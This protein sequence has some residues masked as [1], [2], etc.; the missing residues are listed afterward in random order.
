MR[1]KNIILLS[2]IAFIG[3]V[4]FFLV[5]KHTYES[6]VEALKVK[7]KE[8]FIMAL[9]QELKNRNLNGKLSFYLDLGAVVSEVP[10]TVYWEDS[11]GRYF[12][13]IDSKKKQMNIVNDVNMRSLHSI[14]FRK[15]PLI[16][17]SLILKWQEQL[18]VSDIVLK[19]ALRVSL[20]NQDGSVKLSDSAQCG[21]WCNS[22][23]LVFTVYIGYAYEIEA[24]GYLEYTIWSILYKEMLLFLL[25][26]V[27]F[28]YGLYR[29]WNVLSHKIHTLRTPAVRDIIKE[30]P[31]EIIKEVQVEKLVLKE[32]QRVEDSPLHSYLLGENIIF[33][34][35]Q[36]IIE[37]NGI[38]RNIQAQS[39]LLLDLFLKQK[40][41]GYTLNED[42]IIDKLWPDN[43]GNHK[44]MH[45]AIARLRSF[46]KK[47]DP[48]LSIINK[49][50]TYQLIIS[51]KRIIV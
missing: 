28:G 8:A 13:K 11:T 38:M 6:K 21:E 23:N 17:D 51:G 5:C 36:N 40:D 29:F 12:Y 24:M 33:Y 42:L 15:T 32:V 50:G 30:V 31:V 18:L 4:L 48:S 39:G 26:Y 1:A 20:I 14:V 46:L 25:L 43:S 49:N 22:S 16:S 9:N 3:G 45:K 47:I 7:S 35:D 41:N 10:N 2:V 27:I 19:S 44:R 34:A 37:I